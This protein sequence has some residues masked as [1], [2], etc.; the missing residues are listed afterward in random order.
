MS[1]PVP[2]PATLEERTDDLLAAMDAAESRTAAI[3]GISEGG[4][5]A[6]LFAAT[7]PE[8]TSSLVLYGAWPRVLRAPDFPFEIGSSP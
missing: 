4:S 1:D 5:M 8:R 7:H 6:A 3:F 2:G